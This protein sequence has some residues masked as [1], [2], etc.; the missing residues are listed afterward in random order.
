KLAAYMVASNQNPVLVDVWRGDMVESRHRGAVAVVE[1]RGNVVAAWGDIE[2]TVFARSAIKP[3]QALPLVESGAAES[4][5]VS[6]EE[7]AL[8]CASHGGEPEHV[9][10]ANNWLDRIGLGPDD[11]ECGGHLPLYQPATA[12][13]LRSDD[14]LSALHNNCSGKHVGFLATAIHLGESTH[15]YSHPDHPVQRRV[16]R[17]LED[18]SGE[19]LVDAP[20]GIDGCGIPVTGLSLRATAYAMSRLGNP[21][22]LPVKR[23]R[24]CERVAQAMVNAPFMVAGSKRFCTEVMRV[25]GSDAI[26]KTGAEGFFTAAFPIKGFGVALKID[27]GASRAAEVAMGAILRYLKILDASTVQSLSEHLEPPVQNWAGTPVG[28]ICTTSGWPV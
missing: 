8:A 17:T 24:A 25:T 6:D 13:L 10:T 1:A 11:L 20:T 22:D 23:A 2:R 27:D 28:R 12:A 7:L 9:Q 16:R 4:L 26:V 5:E 18:L 3:L 21:H 15:G 19:K 14:A